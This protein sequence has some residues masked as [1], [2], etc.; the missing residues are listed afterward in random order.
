M[1]Q[2]QSGA[3][4][5]NLA[6]PS[7][8]LR[9]KPCAMPFYQASVPTLL[10]VQEFIIDSREP[11]YNHCGNLAHLKVLRT[12]KDMH[13][14]HLLGN[15]SFI[16]PELK[17]IND[18]LLYFLQCHHSNSA[19]TSAFFALPRWRRKKEWHKLLRH[20][21][22]VKHIPSS[23]W[24]YHIW[25]VQAQS[26][27]SFSSLSNDSDALLMLFSAKIG[28]HSGKVLNDSGATHNFISFEFKQKSGLTVNPD[29]G[30][31]SC[32]GATTQ[33]VQGFVD[34]QISLQQFLG[35]IRFYVLSLPSESAFDAVTGQTWLKRFQAIVDYANE[36][37]LLK[38]K[39][40]TLA[41][42]C[43]PNNSYPLLSALQMQQQ[44]KDD[45]NGYFLMTISS[46][47]TAN[48][49]S[50]SAE[51]SN[52]ALPSFLDSYDAVFQEPP[53]G[54]PPDRGI[55]H[56][57]YTGTA[58]P[59]SKP[60]YRLSPKEKECAETM[61]KELLDKGWIRPS[62]SPYSSP[63]LFVQKKDGSLGMC[64][65]YRPLNKNNKKRQI[66]IALDK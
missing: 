20:M 19:N 48:A 54:L 4:A 34:I 18:C 42:Q 7:P 5:A 14:R 40:N 45:S 17:H 25:F 43:T 63:L 9:A 41:L 59:V 27:M 1:S 62:K 32:G 10:S 36:Q 55:G 8:K 50:H 61:V 26:R 15:R 21:Q 11:F 53:P 12:L 23:P 2:A 16:Q 6:H 47:D 37:V 35:T 33:T 58:P 38:S 49:D 52:P 60:M 51:H 44:F 64:V 30:R 57:I 3:Q 22:L 46:A 39:S 24:D 65:D 31:V 66:S 29:S 56:S 28:K 13:E